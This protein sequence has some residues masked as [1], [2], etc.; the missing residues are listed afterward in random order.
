[1]IKVDQEIVDAANGDCTRACL[2][3]ILELP[4]DAI[5]NFIRFKDKWYFMLKDFVRRLGYDY[6]GTGYPNSHKLNESYNING[7]VIASVPS[8]TF[9]SGG[10][11]VIMDLN[12]VVVHDPNPNKLW[13]DI[14]ALETKELKSWMLLEP[15]AE[16]TD[17][18]FSINEYD[19]DGDLLESGIHLHFGDT[20]I[21]VAKNKEGLKCF[22]KQ[23]QKIFKEI[24][25]NY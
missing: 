15:V 17:C 16:Y 9:P 10:H 20:R 24:H 19:S 25:E 7:L 18:S 4:I 23:L 8:K 14:N 11:S 1:M 6:I 2:A 22:E 21:R 12:G 5:P 13:Q 3:S